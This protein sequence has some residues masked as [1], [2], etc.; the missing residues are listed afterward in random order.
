M[1][2]LGHLRSCCLTCA[3]RPNWLVGYNQS[4]SSFG[5]DTDKCA[6]KL[7]FNHFIDLTCFALLKCLANANDRL[8]VRVKGSKGL[9]INDCFGLTEV[10][11]ALR[12]PENDEV[13]E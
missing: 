10:F 7:C 2:F 4:I 13:C 11:T 9:L 6:F 3:D 8:E 12:V 1:H 5:G